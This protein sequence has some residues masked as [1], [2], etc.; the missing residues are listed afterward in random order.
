MITD[1]ASAVRYNDVPVEPSNSQ[2]TLS[3]Q[4]AR[5][6]EIIFEADTRAGRFF[7]IA[8]FWAILLSV[9]TV[10]LE[11][12]AQIRA[13]YGPQLRL[14]EWLFTVLFSIEYALRLYSVSRPVKYAVSF[15]GLVDLLAVMPS[16]LSLF[17][18]G[19]QSLLI[20]RMLRL[21]RI[22]RVLKLVH[23]LSEAAALTAALKA[24][25]R[26]ITVFLGTVLN[27]AAIVGALMYLIEGEASGFTSIPRSMYWAVVTMTT[28]GYG[29]IV[30]VTPLGQLVSALLMIL[31]YGILAVPT[32]IVS[33]ELVRQDRKT[34]LNTQA[35]SSCSAEGHDDDATHCKYCG[36]RL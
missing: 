6:H 30:P 17:V 3:R 13:S 5:L 11:S 10:A 32:G 1:G 27:I 24:S 4:R 34:S 20:I 8:L 33:A 28:V 9:A 25:R 18:A 31:G 7:D 26:K 29:T 12:V 36:E 14:L 23:Y 21:L 19:A 22:F 2:S 16:Y 15:F 35:C